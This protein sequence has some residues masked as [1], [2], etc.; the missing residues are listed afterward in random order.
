MT[1]AEATAFVHR[2]QAMW[3]PVLKEIAQKQQM[4]RGTIDSCVY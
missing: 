1:A 3:N 4:Q 2:Q